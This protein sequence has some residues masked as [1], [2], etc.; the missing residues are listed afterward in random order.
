MSPDRTCLPVFLSSYAT[1]ELS[2]RVVTKLRQ[3]LQALP[4][5]FAEC[6]SLDDLGL[7]SLPLFLAT[8]KLSVVSAKNNNIDDIPIE[9]FR[10][11]LIPGFVD[12]T[13]NPLRGIPAVFRDD[14]RKAWG[15]FKDRAKGE[16]AFPFVR[17]ALLGPLGAGKTTVAAC[18]AEACAGATPPEP[19]LFS[20]PLRPP[21][22]RQPTVGV[23]LGSLVIPFGDGGHDQVPPE[24]VIHAAVLDF[25]GDEVYRRTHSL[26]LNTS[27]VFCAVFDLTTVSGDSLPGAEA[28]L[29]SLAPFAGADVIV[30]GTRADSFKKD[31]GELARRLGVLCSQFVAPLHAHAFSVETFAV[32]CASRAMTLLV[33]PQGAEDEEAALTSVSAALG[34]KMRTS[35][36]VDVLSRACTRTLERSDRIDASLWLRVP[37]GYVDFAMSA[38]QR[39]TGLGAVMRAP[40]FAWQVG[41]PAWESAE[42]DRALLYLDSR[43]IIKYLP[44][45]QIVF[46]DPTW[47]LKCCYA[48]FW[49]SH[50]THAADNRKPSPINLF[51]RNGVAGA[52]A[53]AERLVLRPDLAARLQAADPERLALAGLLK[54]SVLE[55]LLEGFCDAP[56]AE[57]P[58]VLDEIVHI[59]C[60]HGILITRSLVAHDAEKVYLVPALRRGATSMTPVAPL[61]PAF[62][63][64]MELPVSVAH[65]PVVAQVLGNIRLAA[66]SLRTLEIVD[67][68]GT[69]QAECGIL[70]WPNERAGVATQG[71]CV[72]CKCGSSFVELTV[73]VSESVSRS[74]G[75]AGVQACVAAALDD[76]PGQPTGP[77]TVSCPCG[78]TVLREAGIEDRVS[79]PSCHRE[80]T[81]APDDTIG[82]SD[83]TTVGTEADA[84]RLR[85][86][87]ERLRAKPLTKWLRGLGP[88]PASPRSLFGDL[89]DRHLRVVLLSVVEW[90]AHQPGITPTV[91]DPGVL[92]VDLTIPNR[93][94]VVVH[95]RNLDRLSRGA[96]AQPERSAEVTVERVKALIALGILRADWDE[97]AGLDGEAIATRL[98]PI[99]PSAADLVRNCMSLAT[100]RCHPLFWSWERGIRFLHDL[101]HVLG[102]L[103]RGAR[104]VETRNRFESIAL[105]ITNGDLDWS[106]SPAP[107]LRHLGNNPPKANETAELFFKRQTCFVRHNPSEEHLSAFRLSYR[108]KDPQPGQRHV[109]SAR[110]SRGTGRGAR[111]SPGRDEVLLIEVESGGVEGA[112]CNGPH[113]CSDACKVR[114]ANCENL[115]ALWALL[116]QLRNA[117]EH[118]KEWEGAPDIDDLRG[119][120]GRPLMARGIF[121]HFVWPEAERDDVPRFLK[122]GELIILAF[123]SFKRLVQEDSARWVFFESLR[124]YLE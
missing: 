60:S 115:Q 24:T 98:D 122:R 59:L 43:L 76:L 33:Q 17:I 56:I 10:D 55:L 28:W 45:Q 106:F 41:S 14:P 109:A 105:T 22:V 86:I 25:A 90:I 16:V 94:R 74:V 52:Q 62:Q 93:L 87:E 88:A 117:F 92:L 49:W 61:D 5:P 35:G 63:C 27:T 13:G 34:Q 83:D 42:L 100:I 12:L 32:D 71:A 19:G 80:I 82:P 108:L 121:I 53:F 67:L 7:S 104:G 116:H 110:G 58:G 69:D 111:A 84:G 85:R 37:S 31:P 57:V 23:D 6:V 113:S 97:L 79:C 36:F 102:D 18:F 3:A 66:L 11:E 48:C 64:R 8:S 47:I 46:P 119:V 15:F 81:I 51:E 123:N 107:L 65:L 40:E 124:G 91:V 73:S 89:E 2:Q 68:W 38:A 72:V 1:I 50:Y 99:S 9:F 44:G 96:G 70:G 95:Q 20:R 4:V 78:T 29:A 118:C 114:C 54:R 120:F 39:T 103:R 26:F 77:M 21:A 30:L 101:G 75:V 112:D